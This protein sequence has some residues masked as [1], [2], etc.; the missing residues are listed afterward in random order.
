MRWRTRPGCLRCP[1]ACPPWW[2]MTACRRRTRVLLRLKLRLRPP[3]V[4]LTLSIC[5]DSELIKNF[6]PVRSGLP[7][8]PAERHRPPRSGQ[9]HTEL[10]L[11]TKL[12]GPQKNQKELSPETFQQ[13]DLI[14]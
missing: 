14:P 7:V 13:A 11:R 3:S 6:R 4:A 12:E 9:A 1:G 10:G 5:V 8:A 2:A